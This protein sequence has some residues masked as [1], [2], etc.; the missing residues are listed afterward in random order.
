MSAELSPE[1][2]ALLRE[3]DRGQVQQRRD[4]EWSLDR[5][6]DYSRAGRYTLVTARVNNLLDLGLIAGYA[7]SPESRYTLRL[8]QAGR[9]AIANA[10][11]AP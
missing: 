11:A 10:S 8:T 5:G 1:S 2:V 4:L 7:A 6:P 3:I 9:E